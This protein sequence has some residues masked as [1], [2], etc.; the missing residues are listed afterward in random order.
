M[1]SPSPIFIDEDISMEPL[2]QLDM[3]YEANR[4]EK[5]N[6]LTDCATTPYPS[7]SEWDTR[8]GSTMED[9]VESKGNQA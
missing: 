2:Q 8:E 5:H 4:L 3:S 1:R 9:A 6:S 7:S